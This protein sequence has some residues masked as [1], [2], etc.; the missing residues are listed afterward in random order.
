MRCNPSKWL[1][2][3]VPIAFLSWI[4][5]QVEHESIE[6]DLSRRTQDALQRIGMDWATPI[7]NGRDGVL[8]GKSADDTAPARALATVREGW[9]VRVALDRSEMLER[10]DKFFW[11]AESRGDGRII[12][13]GFVPDEDTRKGLLNAAKTE[14]PKTPIIDEMKLARGAPDRAAWL[15]GASFALSQIAQLKKGTAE[16]DALRLTVA[17]E[18]ATMPAYRNVRKALSSSVPPKVVLAFEKISPPVINPYL[19]NAALS[20][21]K[22][23]IG[24]YI[25]TEAARKEI[26]AHARRVMPNAALTDTAETAGGAPD[27]W[28][29]AAA[30]A[31]TQLASL[32]VGTA[33]IKG[34]EFTFVG[35]AAD[36]TTAA[37]VRKALKSDVPQSFKLVE[38]IGYPRGIKSIAGYNMMIAHSGGDVEVSGNIPSEAARAA[39]ID[40][41]K[42][43]FRGRNVNDKLK[44]LSGA[45]EG[46][47]QCIIAGLA[48]LPRLAEGSSVLAD[49]ALTVTGSTADYGVAQGVPEEVRTAVGQTCTADVQI[50]FTGD[51]KGNLTW[52]AALDDRGALRLSGDVPDDAARGRLI[53]AAQRLFPNARFSDEMRLK[54]APAE[55]WLTVALGGLTSLSKLERGE[56]QLTASA[57]AVKGF[58]ESEAVA[59]NVRAAVPRDVPEG[60][61]GTAAIEVLSAQEQA[62]NVCQEMMRDATARGVLEFDRAKADLTPDSTLTLRELAEIAAECPAFHIE[63]EGHTDSEGTDERNQRLSDRRAQAVADFLTREGVDARRLTTVGYGAT[64]PIADNNTD[65]GR[66]RNRRI[67]FIVK[68]N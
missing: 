29:K 57:L 44:I 30:I 64:R 12:L 36:E 47:Q 20:A 31:L 63:I 38:R 37:A 5:V 7:F 49:R 26:V 46:W 4:A 40:A 66:A 19:W 45:P 67:E 51:M 2:G 68:V 60:Y 25:P 15:S 16:L 58:A 42:A 9:G 11:S 3:L 13:S 14:F 21:G 33:D 55:P 65:E 43:R 10:V 59:A 27:N 22:L 39:L 35:E 6:A 28:A 18:A 41:V 17:G 62:A 50:K 61:S 34:R 24:G 48:P 53:E 54:A 8:T 23:T 56:A 52:R 32:K 1:L